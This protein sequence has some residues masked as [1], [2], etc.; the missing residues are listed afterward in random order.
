MNCF[1]SDIKR[2]VLSIGFAVGL[3]LQ[4]T[5]LFVFKEDSTLYTMSIPLV[6]TLPFSCGFLDEYK[7]GFIKFSLSRSTFFGYIVSKFFAACI[8]GGILEV[9]SVWIYYI[10]KNNDQQSKPQYLLVFLSAILWASVSILFAAISKSKYLTFGGS[11]VIYYFM[12]ILFERYWKSLYCLNPT[13][14][15]NPSHTWIFDNTGITILVSLLITI[16]FL[17]YYKVLRGLLINA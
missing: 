5:I 2:A 13:E 15:Y 8:S 10:F 11:F 9:A 3:I 17:I 16:M 1:E 6:C 7:N 4:V 14:W 12:I